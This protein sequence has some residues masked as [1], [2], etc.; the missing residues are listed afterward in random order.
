VHDP[1]MRV[2][3]KLLVQGRAGGWLFYERAGHHAR[4]RRR[5][6]RAPD[7]R[8][9]LVSARADPMGVLTAHVATSAIVVDADSVRAPHWEQRAR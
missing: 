4:T 1:R 2:G 5:A 7:R 6:R 9:P 8:D 3:C